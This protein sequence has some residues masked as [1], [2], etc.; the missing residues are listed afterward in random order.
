MGA[1]QQVV[2]EVTE[3]EAG[4]PNVSAD[5]PALLPFSADRLRAWG[6]RSA[7]AR[8][9]GGLFS[10]VGFWSMVDQ[11]MVSAG[12]FLTTILL[13]RS[14]LPAEYGVYAL[15]FGLILMMNGF[16]SAFI[17]YGMSLLGASK[18]EAEIRPLAGGSLVLTAGLAILLGTAVGTTAVFFHRTSLGPWLLLALLFW[19]LQET[20]RRALMCRLRFRDALWGD[21]LSYL[22]QTAW[23]AFLFF[24]HRLTIVSAFGV[25]AATS[26]GAALL[27]AVQLRLTWP[28]FRGAFRLIPRFWNTGRWALLVSAAQAFI[29]QALL[30]FLA[31]A[32]TAEVA[33]FQSALNLLRATNPVMFG[34]GSV[35]LPTVAAQP[36]KPEAGLYAARRYGLLGALVLLPYFA[37]LFL[38]PRLTLHLFYGAGSPYAGLGLELRMLVLGSALGYVA[39]ILGSYYYG[40]SKSYIVLRSQLVAVAFTVIAGLVLVMKEGVLGAAVAYVLTFAAQTAVL[41]W[42]LR[43]R[44]PS[45]MVEHLGV[46]GG[47]R[48]DGE[49]N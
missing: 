43:C 15:L 7:L 34:I 6:L 21:A 44:A 3:A 38:F 26:A 41:V 5:T 47:E 4:R 12:N 1:E 2:Y 33:G 10:S 17:W 18:S 27:Q 28:D 46:G 39:Y 11:G 35:L 30:W 9:N 14:L 22:G 31:F 40:L 16:H 48:L 37:V 36:G 45:P 32:G 24:A 29:G 49:G 25:M 42:F 19:Q 23:I 8:A 13:A 20:T